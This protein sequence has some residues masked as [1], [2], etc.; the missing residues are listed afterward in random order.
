[1]MAAMLVERERQIDK[2]GAQLDTPCVPQHG[3]LGGSPVTMEGE[4]KRL[5]DR[6]FAEGKGS[7]AHIAQEELSEA[8]YAPTDELRREEL[9]QLATVVMG[10]IEAIDHRA[11]MF[12]CLDN[13]A[14]PEEIGIGSYVRVP[15]LGGSIGRIVKINHGGGWVVEW[16]YGKDN[17]G[18]VVVA[19]SNMHTDQLILC[20]RDEYVHARDREFNSDALPQGDLPT[21][22]QD[23]NDLG[24]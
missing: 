22:Q 20:G 11:G 14:V 10:W 24:C 18:E 9:V 16:V 19:T 17:A 4:A 2:F 15:C 21:P 12:D 3:W 6:A 23:P 8:T 1:M 13:M 5:C 7:W